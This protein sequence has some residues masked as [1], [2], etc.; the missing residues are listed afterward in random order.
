MDQLGP[1]WVHIGD[2]LFIKDHIVACKDL[3]AYEKH[4]GTGITSV[5]EVDL[6][7]QQISFARGNNKVG[8]G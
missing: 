2:D 3:N 5:G 7:T 6:N 4:L 8:G 1:W